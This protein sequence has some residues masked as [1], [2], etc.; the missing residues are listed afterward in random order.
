MLLLLLF[1]AAAAV[2]AASAA[3]VA[4]PAAA[5]A[6]IATASNALG[7]LLYFVRDN[8]RMRILRPW[9]CTSWSRKSAVYVSVSAA[10]VWVDSSWVGL[11]CLSRCCCSLFFTLSLVTPKQLT[12]HPHLTSVSLRHTHSLTQTRTNP[13]THT[14]KHKHTHART[15]TNT[16]AHNHICWLPLPVLHLAT[17]RQPKTLG[18]MGGSN[19]GLLTGEWDRDRYCSADA[20]AR[21]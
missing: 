1:A 15:H 13:V 20:C 2:V 6:A 19:G 17:R 5:A 4:A 21:V 11:V 8:R 9:P 3:V 16:N 12:N 7:D 10:T 18:C 14:H